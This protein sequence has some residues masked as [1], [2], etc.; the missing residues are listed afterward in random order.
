MSV[1]LF[2][3]ILDA[4]CCVKKKNV[5]NKKKKKKKKRSEQIFI[6]VGYGPH[7]AKTHLNANT[8]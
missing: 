1:V 2:C 3:Y 5:D 4:V 8:M 7:T 6:L